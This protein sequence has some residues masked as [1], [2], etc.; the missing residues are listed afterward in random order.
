[1]GGGAVDWPRLLHRECGPYP[2]EGTWPMVVSLLEMFAAID[3]QWLGL[4]IRKGCK[5][6]LF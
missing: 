4:V 5:V 2:S 6:V 1:M 3:G